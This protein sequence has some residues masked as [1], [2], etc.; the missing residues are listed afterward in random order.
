MK[1]KSLVSILFFTGF[2]INSI[3]LL[4]EKFFPLYTGVL[5]DKGELI[6]ESGYPILWNLG[7]CLSLLGLLIII[8]GFIYGT[9]FRKVRS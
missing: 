4:I 8:F 1:N 2:V 6:S 3:G 5:N 9:F 7:K